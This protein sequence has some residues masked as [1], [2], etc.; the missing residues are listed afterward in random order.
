MNEQTVQHP[1]IQLRGLSLR[2][3]ADWEQVDVPG[4]ALVAVEPERPKAQTTFRPNLVVISEPSAASI[5]QL[6]TRAMASAMADATDTYM[7]SCDIWPGDH[8]SRCLEFTHRVDSLLVDVVKYLFAT[9]DRAVELTF[10]CLVGQR[11]AYADLATYIA[12][13]MQF[14]EQ[15]R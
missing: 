1:L 12:S 8:P 14:T 10:S 7:V 3:P 15:E 11:P 5:Q 4:T 2:A 9:G 6:S 13:S